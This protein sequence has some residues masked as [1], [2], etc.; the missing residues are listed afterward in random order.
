MISKMGVGSVSP[1]VPLQ[2]GFLILEI[3]HIRYPENPEAEDVEGEKEALTRKRTEGVDGLYK[4]FGQE[5]C[6]SSTG[7][8][9]TAGL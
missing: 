8:H 2:S 9:R 1:I 4:R 3:P 6:Q 5:I 7:G